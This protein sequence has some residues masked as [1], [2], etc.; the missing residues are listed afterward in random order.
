MCLV[1]RTEVGTGNMNEKISDFKDV[2]V[3]VAIGV[4]GKCSEERHRK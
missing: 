3:D 1:F 4:G 2:D